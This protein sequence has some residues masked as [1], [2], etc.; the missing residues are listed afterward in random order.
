M[1]VTGLNRSQPRLPR[2]VEAFAR[3]TSAAVASRR[4]SVRADSRFE[5]GFDSGASRFNPALL[6]SQ[7]APVAAR[8]V[9]P[10]RSLSAPEAIR[11]STRPNAAIEDNQTVSSHL[12]L[13]GSGTV[14]KLKVDL[15]L[16][17]TWRGD[18][19]VKL[20]SPSGK[21]AV[22]S[23][24]EGGSA[25]DLKG[26]FELSDFAGEPVQ[27]QWTLTVEDKASRDTG[28][29]K[30]WGLEITPAEQPEPP[31]PPTPE[32][33]GG[34]DPFAGLRDEALLR[35]IKSTSQGKDVKGYTE[36]R[37]FMFGDLDVN[38]EGNVRCVYTGREVRGGQIPNG[39]DMNTEH[40]WPQSKGATG[41]AKSDVHHLFPTD[42]KANSIRSSYPF[43]EVVN[44]K[45]SDPSGAKLGT[46]AQGRTVFEPP[47]EH[48]GNVARAMFYFSAEYG[49]AIPDS[50]EAVLK[51]WNHEDAV[52]VAELERNRR[53]AAFQGNR[54][55]F[56]EHAQLADRISDF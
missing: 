10:S 53:I 55:Q 27:G 7:F 33:P 21:S 25:D 23:N 46:D 8:P 43:G 20:T 13:S 28:V 17:H 54:N 15:D 47:D 5:S 24:R 16:E 39:S 2:N 37:R 34:E 29:L 4:S 49:K 1:N 32:P 50:E 31:T 45:W 42:S 36:A 14:D 30:G 22:L 18:L 51:Q 12:E 40:T 35:A 3:A 44:A 38:A 48:K 9:V 52:D 19:V 26:S 56:V 11:A 6:G 41:D